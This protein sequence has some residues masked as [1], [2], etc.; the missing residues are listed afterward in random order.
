MESTRRISSVLKVAQLSLNTQP[1]VGNGSQTESTSSTMKRYSSGQE[2]KG[3]FC[4][5]GI[6]QDIRLVE[7]SSGKITELSH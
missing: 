7:K 3:Q 6:M 5:N 1:P 2:S 4:C